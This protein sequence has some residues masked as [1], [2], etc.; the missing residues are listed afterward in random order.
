M[1]I[2]V[3]ISKGLRTNVAS[4]GK[5][6]PDFVIRLTPDSNAGLFSQLSTGAHKTFTCG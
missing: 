2:F 5:Q 6:R 3:S 1:S 4:G